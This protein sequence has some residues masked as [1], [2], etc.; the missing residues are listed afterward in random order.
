MPLCAT[1][2]YDLFL[3]TQLK[4]QLLPAPTMAEQYQ[5]VGNDPD[6]WHYYAYPIPKTETM[7]EVSCDNPSEILDVSRSMIDLNFLEIELQTDNPIF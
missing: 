6:A 1:K 3:K 5:A 4:L 7:S 2:T